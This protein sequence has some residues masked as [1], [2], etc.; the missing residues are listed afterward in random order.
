MPPSV[1]DFAAALVLTYSPRDRAEEDGYAAWVRRV[2][3]PFFNAVPGMFRH[4][5]WWL[6]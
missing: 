4:P 1:S 6:I 3:H 2:H 5:P